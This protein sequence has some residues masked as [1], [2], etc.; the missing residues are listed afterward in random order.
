MASGRTLVK[1][2]NW[3]HPGRQYG[4]EIFGNTATKMGK[5]PGEKLYAPL[6]QSSKAKYSLQ[7]KIVEFYPSSRTPVESTGSEFSAVVRPKRVKNPGEKLYA[8]LMRSSKQCSQMTFSK[9]RTNAVE[10]IRTDGKNSV[11]FF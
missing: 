4:I 2:T 7:I 3:S 5:N 6:V 9:I 8:P 10:K 11:I 1:S